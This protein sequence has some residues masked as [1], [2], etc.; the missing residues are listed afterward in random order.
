MQPKPRPGDPCVL[1]IFGAAGDLTK[2]LLVPA[3]GNLRR[4]GL[5][6]KEF[7]VI[8]ASRRDTDNESFRRDLGLGLRKSAN[9]AADGWLA[10]RVYHLQGEFNDPAA[11]KNLAKLLAETD[12]T[13]HAGGNYL[14]YIPRNA[15]TGVCRHCAA[16]RTRRP[17]S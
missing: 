6:P 5:L 17:R 16:A 14:F 13:H 9:E 3:L 2:R 8:G 15:R 11:Y 4:A 12:N 1:V 7:A 10:E